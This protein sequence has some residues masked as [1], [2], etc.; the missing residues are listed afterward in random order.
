[1]NSISTAPI[2]PPTK[3]TYPGQIKLVEELKRNNV[4]KTSF[5]ESV[6]KSV[7][8]A[9]FTKYNA[10][11]DGAQTIGYQSTISAPHMHGIAMELLSNHLIKGKRSLDVGSGSGYL[12]L[13]FAKMMADQPDAVSYGVEHIPELVKSS[14]ANIRKN[15]PTY[16]DSGKVVITVGDGRLGLPE[17]APYDAI[18]VGAAAAQIPKELIDQLANG[19]RMVI[20][21]GAAGEYQDFMVIDKDSKGNIKQQKM[22]GVA[23]VPLTS[24]QKQ[25]PD[26]P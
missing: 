11:Y 22:F 2:T 16:L 24:K 18:H 25:W 17:H 6:M 9:D 20:P 10:Y 26:D 8:R 1:M 21:V 3:P 19:G 23:Y 13:C 14:I 12:T 7:D 5:V 4:I 15:H